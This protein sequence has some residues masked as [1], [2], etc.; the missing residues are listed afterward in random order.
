M[1][2][3]I[4]SITNG[5]IAAFFFFSFIL[6]L[7]WNSLVAGHLG[8]GPTLNYLQTAGLWFLITIV[9]AWAGIASRSA[10]GWRTIR[11][12][13]RREI[14][15]EIERRLEDTFARRFDAAEED[16]GAQ[17]ERKIKRGFARWVDADESTDWSELG[18]LIE[19]KI[20]RKLNDWVD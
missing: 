10:F 5:G 16:L 8:W 18:E 14:G 12:R 17:I 20:R 2:L 1:R 13:T 6:M 11:S 19:R 15:D 7:L 9:F 3:L 4:R